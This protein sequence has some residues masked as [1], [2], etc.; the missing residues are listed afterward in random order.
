MSVDYG[1]DSIRLKNRIVELEDLLVGERGAVRRL[2]EHCSRQARVIHRLEK[3]VAGLRD[4]L[5]KKRMNKQTQKALDL[6]HEKQTVVNCTL[7]P[8]R[9]SEPRRRGSVTEEVPMCGLG[10]TVGF[11]RYEKQ[12]AYVSMNCGLVEIITTTEVMSPSVIYVTE[13][14]NW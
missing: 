6:Q 12:L 8:C 14:I 9:K 5:K 2:E 11:C 1:I 3:T 4:T 7:C 10:Y 13:E